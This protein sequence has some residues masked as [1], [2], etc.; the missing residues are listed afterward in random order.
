[1]SVIQVAG[2][3]TVDWLVVSPRTTALQL[4][5]E[6]A[7]QALTGLFP[8]PGGAALLTEVLTRVA[9]DTDRSDRHIEVHGVTIAPEILRDP[10]GS[11]V[12]RTISLWELYPQSVDK[13]SGPGRSWRMRDFVGQE[14]AAA[15]G[16]SHPIP[17]GERAVTCLVLDDADLGF[18]S[19]S[20]SWP[21]G[22]R[23]GG[24][25]PEHVIMKMTNPLATGA[26]WDR[27]VGHGDSLTVYL[28]LGD[29][30]N[31]SASVGQALSWEQMSG[32]IVAAVRAD[33]ALSQ[34]ARVVVATGHSGAVVVEAERALLVFDPAHQA[35]DWERDRPGTT[36]GLGTCLVAAMAAGCA[37]GGG[38]PDWCGFVAS[39]LQ[40][41]RLVHEQGYGMDGHWAGLQ[42]PVTSVAACLTA[43]APGHGFET[44]EVGTS[45]DWTILGARL[46]P[47]HLAA[48]A[49]IV[50][51]GPRDACRGIPIEKM[52]SWQS[53]DRR[54]IEAMRSVR[55]IIEQYLRQA[56]RPRPLSIAVFGPPGAGKSFAIKQMAKEWTDGSAA[57]TVLPAFNLSQFASAADLGDPFQRI[58]DCAV[59]GTLPLVFW[60]EFDARLGDQELG[61]LS[62]FLAPM[63]DGEFLDEGVVQPIGPAIFVFAG[64]THHTMGAFKAKAESVPTYVKATDFL[65]R[66]RGYVDIVGLDRSEADGAHLIRRAFLLRSLFERR[67]PGIIDNGRVAIDPGVLR[68]FL[69]VERFGHGARSVE[70]IIDMSALAGKSRF[71]RSTLP[72]DHQLALH[73]PV[74]EWAQLIATGDEPASE[75]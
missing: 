8:Q 42:F 40:A 48:A 60:D 74:E 59:R 47:D 9:S 4:P 3:T 44:Q 39:G 65:S 24:S 61:W 5:D 15:T 73:A 37:A 33:E 32:E 6:W 29:L 2:D 14:P 67:W 43:S 21:A 17:S 28:A 22:L 35:G 13:R 62:R 50:E 53:A 30:R 66:L 72:A 69:G 34:A 10:K 55:N 27:L 12:T 19:R 45:P 64:G 36:L 54:E 11:S 41:A 25:W 20:D 1:M 49:A 46:G 63:Q 58:R 7:N 70:A 18:R 56:D 52:G 16:P 51:V 26:L 38:E 71:E 23:E 68:A 57:I 31:E 75:L